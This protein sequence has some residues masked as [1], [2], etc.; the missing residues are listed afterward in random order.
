MTDA[1]DFRQQQNDERRRAED[2]AAALAESLRT[3]AYCDYYRER[4]IQRGYVAPIGSSGLDRYYTDTPR[5]D[6]GRVNKKEDR[7]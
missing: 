4:D 7:K 1:P 5:A 2:E 3:A 6:T